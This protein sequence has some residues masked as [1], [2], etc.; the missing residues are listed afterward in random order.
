MRRSLQAF[1]ARWSKPRSQRHTEYLKGYTIATEALGRDDNFD[2]QID[3]IVRVEAGRL[4]YA[5]EHYYSNGGAGD[6]VVIEL[7]RGSY[8]PTFH[9]N[10]N[11]P[12]RLARLR[13]D[14]LQPLHKHFQLVMMIVI[15]ST[16]VCLIVEAIEHFWLR[17]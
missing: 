8:V 9:R 7:P 11:A 15:V 1:C 10:R 16:T 5:L 2:P 17:P 13:N 6:P 12:G 4:R 3:P 14:I